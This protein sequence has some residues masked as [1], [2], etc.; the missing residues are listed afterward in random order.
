MWSIPMHLIILMHHVSSALPLNASSNDQG[1][2]GKGKS[3]WSEA[4]EALLVQTL[5]DQKVDG[6]W[7]D[8]NPKATAWQ[9]CLVALAGSKKESGGAPKGINVLK[10]WWWKVHLVMSMDAH[11]WHLL[12]YT[13]Q[14]GIQN[15]Q[16]KGSAISQESA[17]M[18]WWKR[19]RQNWWSGMHTARYAG[20][21]YTW[22]FLVPLTFPSLRAFPRQTPSTAKASHSLMRL[23]TLLT[24]L[25]LLVNLHSRQDNPWALPILNTCALLL[26]LKTTWFLHWLCSIGDFHQIHCHNQVL[27]PTSLGGGCILR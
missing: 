10:S 15:H 22:D 21:V 2:K 4:D 8:N 7:G 13:A 27:H 18:R 12:Y 3:K 20:V 5:T 14:I 17:G 9:A 6:Y 23:G 11:I 1:Q 25:V 24:V 26:N 16:K 19:S